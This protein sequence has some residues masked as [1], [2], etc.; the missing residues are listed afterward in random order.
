[1][2]KKEKPFWEMNSRELARATAKFDREFITDTFHAMSRKDRAVWSTWKRK[3]GRPRIGQG[4]TVVSVS[5]EKDLLQRSDALA[6]KL[7]ISR[8]NLV[9]RGLKAV[10]A[11]EGLAV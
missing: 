5:I 2:K 10:M 7:K 8:A 1:M 9:A 6:R 4:V 11:A 3:V